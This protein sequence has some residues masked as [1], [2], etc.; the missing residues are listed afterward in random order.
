[1]PGT[2]I[3]PA[4]SGLYYLQS[5]YYDPEIS[6]FLNSDAYASTGQGIL[7]YNIFSYCN[8][9]PAKHVDS[10][11][12][13]AETAFDVASLIL[14]AVEVSANPADLGAWIGLVGDTVDLIPFV[15]GVGESIRIFRAT[16]K[17]SDGAGDLIDTYRNLRKINAG[18]GNEV[19]HILE[20][21]FVTQLNLNIKENDMLSIALSKSDHQAYTKQWRKLAYGII[22]G[23]DDV[24]R[25]VQKFM[26]IIP[27]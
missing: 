1:M 14:S 8:N 22:H 3:S 27:N 7:G 12:E 6:R 16:G 5:R 24:L 9:N 15:T 4:E 19:H 21:R 20:K 13:V 18:T 25:R 23:F 10:T 11:G 26:R 17:I 2:Y